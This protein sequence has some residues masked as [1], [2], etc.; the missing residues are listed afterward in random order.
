MHAVTFAIETSSMA[1]F[2]RVPRR[3]RVAIV[4][5]FFTVLVAG[6][7][8]VAGCS[9]AATYE[10][11]GQVLVIDPG[12][13][14]ITVKHE[15]V[16][17]LMAG[18]T[19]PF[20]VDDPKRLEGLTVGDLIVAKLVVKDST[21]YLS[22]IERTGH[23]EVTAPAPTPRM[24]LLERGQE[25]P[26]TALVDETGQRRMLADWRGRVLAVTFIY[27][28][29]PFPDFCPKMDRQFKSA[30]GVILADSQLRNRA[31]LLSVT[32]DPDF[33]TP[34]VL[35]AHAK[36][37]GADSAVWHFA[38]GERSAIESLASRFGV[39]VMREGTAAEGITHNLRTAVIGS[40]GR[41]S[42]MLT[43]NEW[44]PAELIDAMRRAR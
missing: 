1:A 37:V 33:D 22:A 25:V 30:Q 3:A 41:L 40:D 8:T 21:G 13:Q 9:R 12:R 28:R 43:G 32:F 14:E 10:L 5:T 17:G 18:M 27:T 29:C 19:M 20:K 36:Q 44:T 4:R 11:R 26:N 23:E 39:S 2:T 15:D 38:T 42:A 24:E 16:R 35:A 7:A 31:A 6:C 34:S